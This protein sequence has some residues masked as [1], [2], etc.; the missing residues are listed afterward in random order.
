MKTDI[1]KKWGNADYTHDPVCLA[2]F[3]PRPT[4]ILITTAP[5]AG[6]TWMQQIL[7]QLHTGGD[8]EFKSIDEV[9]PWLELPRKNSST[10]ERLAYYELLENPRIFK[11]HC[12]YPQTPGSDVVRIILSSRDPRDCCVSFYHH[13]MDM[14]DE[15]IAEVNI[16]RLTS[17]NEYFDQW[18]EHGPWFRNIESWWPHKDDGNL[19]WLRYQDM[20]QDLPGAIDSILNFL[21]WQRTPE[22]MERVLRYTS[23]EWMKEHTEKFS[24]QMDHTKS[25]FKPGGF[26]RKGKVG[27]YKILLKAE[28]E[29]AILDKAA[30]TL[31]RECLDFL[32]L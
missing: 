8:T 3:K 26:I 4:D 1:D 30:A 20:K 27:D 9:V 14:T 23:F 7:H 19:L 15:A 25:G 2:N 31:P 22:E 21:N 29:S 5:K 11:T 28:Q 6:T 18:I 24:N 32:E 10:E 12:T 16:N 17:F 13:I